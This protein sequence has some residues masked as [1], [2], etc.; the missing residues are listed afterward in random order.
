[1]K[2]EKSMGKSIPK[3]KKLPKL[4]K[5]QKE[6]D[7]LMQQVGKKIYKNS[8]LGG[9]TQVMH[10][11]IPKSVSARLRYDWE[12]LIPLTNAQHCRL[13]QSPDDETVVQIIKAKGGIE[14]YEKLRKIGRETIK[15]TRDYY[16]SVK[17]ILE[18]L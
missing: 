17:E 12:N 10:H 2:E 18:K 9:P 3:K 6:C 13:H 4:G 15:V 5:L 14:W 11:L 16:L 7:T 1:M 8:I